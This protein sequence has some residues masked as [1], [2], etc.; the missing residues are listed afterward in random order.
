MA[1]NVNVKVTTT[2]D[3][4]GIDKTRRS[5]DELGNSSGRTSGA[6]SALGFAVKG[7]VAGIAAMA[8]ATTAATV[9]GFGF[10]SAVE[11]AQAQIMAFTKD[12]GKT[13]SILSYVKDEAAKTQFSFTDMAAA[14]AGLIPAS[15][16]SGVALEELIK[17]SEILAALNPAEGLVGASFALKEALSGDF[18]SIVERFNLPRKRL[19]ELKEQGVPAMKAIQTALAEM[20]IDY[21]L[22]AAQG[23]TTAARFD[24]L[25]DK[26]TIMAGEMT[27]PA[28]DKVSVGLLRLAD[29]LDTAAISSK[30]FEITKQITALGR[31]VIEYLN[32]KLVALRNTL[33]DNAP[34]FK[35]FAEQVLKPLALAFGTVLVGAIGLAIDSLN[36]IIAAIKPVIGW[37]KENQLVAQSLALVFGTLATAMAMQAGFAAITAGFTVLTTTTIPA[38]MLKVAAFQAFVASPMVLGAIGIGAALVA[39]NAVKQAAEDARAAVEGADQA[40]KNALTSNQ[41]VLKNLQ[42]LMKNGT[43]EQK[44]RAKATLNGLAQQGFSTGGFTGRGATDEVAGVVHKGEYVIPKSQVDQ[45]TGRPKSDVGGRSISVVQNIYNQVDYNKGISELGW[46]L[47][48]A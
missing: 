35:E 23:Q 19:N 1:G 21:S 27:K 40:A 13:A 15:K 4:D 17:Q 26:F 42:N 39:L 18:V 31:E 32:P 25:K 12:A 24:Q 16:Q 5:L 37:I 6:A 46:R 9:T 22:V 41:E 8:A 20:G 10:N 28:F 14:A 29:S 34:L 36:F 33:A 2:S 11:Q 30:F 38:A 44:A 48:N 47:Q 7:S 43:P 3:T 45:S